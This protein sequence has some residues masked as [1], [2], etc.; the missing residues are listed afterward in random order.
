MIETSDAQRTDWILCILSFVHNELST[1][2]YIF[3]CLEFTISFP[4]WL[5]N[6]FSFSTKQ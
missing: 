1:E 2:C 5:I 4:V 6:F 3:V